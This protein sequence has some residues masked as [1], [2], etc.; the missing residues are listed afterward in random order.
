MKSVCD[1]IEEEYTDCDIRT[2]ELILDDF[3]EEYITE[4]EE[5]YQNV[6]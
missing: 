6:N 4:I 5:R 3:F 2:W 1:F